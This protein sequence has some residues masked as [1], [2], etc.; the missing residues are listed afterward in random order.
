MR[1]ESIAATG[2]ITYMR[3]YVNFGS[4]LSDFLEDKS[5][6]IARAKD[7]EERQ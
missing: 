3:A 6:L 5:G 1:R 4:P 7:N 2:Q